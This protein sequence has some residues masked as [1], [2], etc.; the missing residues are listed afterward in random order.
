MN[1]FVKNPWTKNWIRVMRHPESAA[2]II[3][4]VA[5]ETGENTEAKT[6][7]VTIQKTFIMVLN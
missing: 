2:T 4:E 3:V 1:K 7:E 6:V 5:V